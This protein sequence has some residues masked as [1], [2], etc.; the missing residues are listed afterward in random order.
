LLR[1][2]ST[3]LIYRKCPNA[4]W[5]TNVF[6]ALVLKKGSSVAVH[7]QEWKTVHIISEHVL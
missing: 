1:L 5:E 3:E 4:M 6:L 2:T 7:Q